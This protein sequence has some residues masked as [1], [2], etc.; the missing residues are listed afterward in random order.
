MPT[1]DAPWI[2]TDGYK[3]PGCWLLPNLDAA[4]TALQRAHR[5]AY[6]E[7]PA[8]DRFQYEVKGKGGKL[9]PKERW[10][11]F[12]DPAVQRFEKITTALREVRWVFDQ[13]R[14]EGKPPNLKLAK[15]R[16]SADQWEADHQ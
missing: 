16:T 1:P 15:T 14:L 6:E 4:L 13:L 5:R 12:D 10:P 2:D 11:R 9:D 8:C 7:I 3:P